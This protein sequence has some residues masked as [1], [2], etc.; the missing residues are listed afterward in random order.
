MASQSP[1]RLHGCEIDRKDAELRAVVSGRRAD[2]VQNC[3]QAIAM[4]VIRHQ[5]RRVLVVGRSTADAFVH[6]AG[7]D[8]LRSVALAGV[9]PAFRLALVAATADLIAIYDTAVLEAGRLG[10]TAR[11]FTSDGEALAWL[12]S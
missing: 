3:Y 11:R 10:I 9:P 5:C 2:D 1:A 8:A 4:E 12:A 7:R 6:L